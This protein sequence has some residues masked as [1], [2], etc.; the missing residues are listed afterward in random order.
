[1]TTS[2]RVEHRG[3]VAVAIFNRPEVRNAFDEEAIEALTA[4]FKAFA[5]R[6]DL[7][8]VLIRGEGKD[9]CA[10]ADIRWMRRAAGYKPA[11]SRKDAMRLVG[12]CLAVER[13]PAPVL[14]RAHGA[15]YGGGLGILAAAD[16]VVA[17]D[18]ASFSFSE[19]RLGILPAVVSSFIL[20]KIGPA[21]ARRYFL[22]S[23]TFGA[24]QALAMGLV[25]ETAPEAELDARIDR[26]LSWILRAGPNAVREAKAL[27]RDVD[28]MPMPRRVRHTARALARVR[29]T[30]EAREGLSAFIEKRQ[31]AWVQALPDALP[32][33]TR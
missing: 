16:M 15:C 22:T 1:M 33:K 24:T 6:K 14:A 12:M 19:C 10:G 25:H 17:A 5:S 2:L 11:Q 3:P 31:P 21:N 32:P 13:C 30:P 20:P 4:A 26:L 8:A 27:I 7:R 23:E 18:D 9:F 29:S 28:L